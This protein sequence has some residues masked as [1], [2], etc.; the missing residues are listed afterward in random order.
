MHQP[1]LGVRRQSVTFHYRLYL[2][3]RYSNSKSDANADV[4]VPS[5]MLMIK[6]KIQLE[7]DVGERE[8]G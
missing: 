7:N 1:I 8:K 4:E 3:K 6:H 2:K 5:N